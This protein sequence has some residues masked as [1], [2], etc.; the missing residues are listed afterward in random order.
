MTIRIFTDEY[1][2][3]WRWVDGRA[4]FIRTKKDD[5]DD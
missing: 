3:I 1:G 5:D 2:N 4:I